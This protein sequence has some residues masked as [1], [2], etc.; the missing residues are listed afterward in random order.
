MADATQTSITDLP[1]WAQKYGP[2]LLGLAQ[3]VAFQKQYN[4]ETKEYDIVGPSKYQE[5]DGERIAP[6]SGLQE[7]AFRRAGEMQTSPQLGAATSGAQTAMNR[8][9]GASYSP[10]QAS[11]LQAYAPQLQQFQMGPA[12]RVY[13]GQYNAPTMSAAQTGFQPNLQ[14]FQMGPAERVGA[15]M[16]GGR[17][18]ARYMSPFIEQA[19][20]PQLR[21]AQRSSEMQ[22]MSDQAQAVRSGAFGGSRQAIVE[23]ERQRNLG[24]LQGDI[25][26]RGLQSA[27]EQATQQF[28]QDAA[29]RMQAQQLNQ[30]AGLTVGGQNL[31]AQLGVQ[32]LGTQTG[33]QT[34]LANLSS[35]QQANVQNQAAQLQA[36]GLTA[37]QAMQAAL[38]NQQAGLT[39][40]SQNLQA[41]LG[42][43]QLGSGQSMQAQLANQQAMQQARQLEEQSRQYGAGL[44][45]QGIGLGLQGAGLMGQLGQA[46]FGQGKDITGLQAQLGTQQQQ[47][48]Q[49]DLNQK[50]QDFL[51]QQRHPYQQLEFMS[52]MLRGTPMGTVNTMYTQPP[53]TLGQ[54][55]GLGT[56]LLGFSQA[57]KLFGSKEG[58][59][60]KEYADGGSVTS[61]YN[62][63]GI[64]DKLSD[65]QLQQAR[66]AAINNKDMRRLQ[67]IDEELA[68]R[69]SVRSGLGGAFNSL[70]EE[71]QESVTSMAEGGIVAFAGPS[72]DNNYSLVEDPQ[73]GGSSAGA[74]D[75][76]RLRIESERARRAAEEH[77]ARMKFLRESAPETYRRLLTEQPSAPV[78]A[79]PVR[80]AP[81]QASSAA[82]AAPQPARRDEP[83]RAATIT[84]QEARR[85]VETIAQGNNVE[86]PKDDTKE[87]TEQFMKEFSAKSAPDRAEVK[88]DLEKAKSRAKEIEAR[89][90]GEALMR[91]GFGMAA[92]ASKPGA[93]TGLGGALRSAA[94]ASPIFAES[95]A[96]TNKLKQAAEDNYTKLR[97][98]NR[99]YES[100]LDQ[101][102]MQLASSL[103]NNIN[104]R[105][106]AQANLE[107]QISHQDRMFELEKQKTA[108]ARSQAGRPGSSLEMAYNVLRAD[109]KN[110]DKSNSDLLE[111]A[112]RKV[113]SASLSRTDTTALIQAEKM[114]KDLM[115]KRRM[116]AGTDSKFAKEQVRL[117]D[118]EIRRIDAGLGSRGGVGS[119]TTTGWSIEPVA[120][121]R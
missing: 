100:A 14:Q 52:G 118:E 110:K 115:D 41:L 55:A 48:G 10:T 79:A 27:Y 47:V 4:P 61:D 88:A 75:M 64:I 13:G 37:G 25:R 62:I 50:Y 26:A 121:G 40:G 103:A 42:T 30:Q 82:Q 104:Q 8:A 17:Q 49:Q 90:I 2:E 58:G 78:Q 71:T 44:G 60:V 59:Q 92:A 39:V 29:R 65:A 68:E 85:A 36:Q 95:L 51:N 3:G 108:F 111:D 120:G 83:R 80:A 99:R 16:F 74:A 107:R 94:A 5:Y 72:E 56:G 6:F 12:E 54:F 19:L 53:S 102:N 91:F 66:M 35:Q 112:A 86:I 119:G 7:E 46:E 63:D 22:R 93:G 24:M 97:M 31:A 73:F 69:A 38:A 20:A 114:K 57:S 109:P 45:M 116:F 21:E 67:A 89:G 15:D 70:P 28:N 105:K 43:Q 32:Q 77:E 11:Y 76:D 87:L 84:R 18:A 9:L 1:G 96:E 33:L 98:E 106:L 113:G 101:G 81:A 117:I 23:A 34:A